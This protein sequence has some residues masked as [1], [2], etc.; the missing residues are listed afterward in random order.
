MHIVIRMRTFDV[1]VQIVTDVGPLACVSDHV[2][3]SIV[4]DAYQRCRGGGRRFRMICTWAAQEWEARYHAQAQCHNCLLR[5][6]AVALLR[7]SFACGAAANKAFNSARYVAV[8]L[9]FRLT[10]PDLR[11]TVLTAIP[12]FCRFLG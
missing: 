11:P 1:V 4:G 12:S 3:N 5:H 8:T 6:F 10:V 9:L 7:F 2:A